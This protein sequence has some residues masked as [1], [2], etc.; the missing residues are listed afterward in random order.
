[1]DACLRIW[2]WSRSSETHLLASRAARREGDFDAAA[3]HLHECQDTLHDN[4]PAVLLEW[5]MLCAARGDLDTVEAH[6][7][8]RG[9]QDPDQAPLIL[10]ALGEGYLRLSRILEALHCADDWRTLEPDNVGAW[11]LRGKIHRQVVRHSGNRRRLSPRDTTRSGVSARARYLAVALAQTGRYE[12]ATNHLE[13]LRRSQP[14]D[15]D[16][17]VRLAMCREN[18]DQR[19]DA[20][21]LLDDVLAKHPDH[22]LALRMRGEIARKGGQFSEAEQWLCPAV[23]ALPYDYPAR[24]SL[25]DC[26]RQQQKTEQAEAERGPMEQLRDRQQRQSE[27]LTHLMSQK[28]DDAALQC[29]LGTLYIQWAGPKSAKPG[30]S[31][32]CVSMAIACRRWKCWHATTG[33][34]ATRRRPTSI[35]DRQVS[36]TSPNESFISL[37]GPSFLRFLDR[38]EVLPDRDRVLDRLRGE[39]TRDHVGPAGAEHVADGTAHMVARPPLQAMPHEHAGRCLLQNEDGVQFLPAAFLEMLGGQE[40]DGDNVEVAVAVEV[41]GHGPMDAVHRRQRY[42]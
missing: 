38:P 23:A 22:G 18:M 8:E 32:P 13:L 15:A 40:A 19:E 41:G 12:E 10:E 36:T 28:P 42:A 14:E 39:S 5:A 11:A 16:V 21:A 20:V 17:Q 6:L 1:M 26:L 4:S 37:V 7:K 30:C 3:E 29:E 31:T 33:S 9:R 27:I 2:P 24:Y 35:S 25:W 34:A